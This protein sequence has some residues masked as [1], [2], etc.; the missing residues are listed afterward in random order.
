MSS[1]LPSGGADVPKSRDRIITTVIEMLEVGG[2]EGVQIRE[3]ARRSRVSLQTVYELFGNKSELI[4]DALGLWM[5]QHS[6]LPPPPPKAD[7]SLYEGLMRGFRQVI[8]PW[9]RSPEILKAYFIAQSGPGGE[10][11]ERQGRNAIEPR[12]Q[13]LFLVMEP[14]LA[15]DIYL[16]LENMTLGLLARFTRGEI[17]VEE[18]LHGVERTVFRLASLVE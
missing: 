3:V 12:S 9:E 1:S 13:Q 6:Y 16:I 17:P 2:Y 14:E 4:I 7:E 18:I 8:E 11:L 15:A 5:A 10:R